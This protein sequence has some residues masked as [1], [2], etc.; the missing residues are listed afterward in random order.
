MPLIVN[1][2]SELGPGMTK[3]F[4]MYKDIMYEKETSPF[5]IGQHY[6]ITKSVFSQTQAEL[7]I[8]NPFA[9]V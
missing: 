8:N 7:Q 5:H 3:R 6:M 2:E 1:L 4:Q 9:P